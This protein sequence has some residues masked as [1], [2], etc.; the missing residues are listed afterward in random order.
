MR[1]LVHE[2]LYD[3]R[4][5]FSAVHILYLKLEFFKNLGKE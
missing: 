2:I 1:A 3:M 5:H 4:L